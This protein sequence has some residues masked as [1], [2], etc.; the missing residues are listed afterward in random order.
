[1]RLLLSVVALAALQA[2]QPQL[3]VSVDE[4][5]VSVGED[6]PLSRDIAVGHYKPINSTRFLN[7][8][9][10]FIFHFS[11]TGETRLDRTAIGL[12][13]AYQDASNIARWRAAGNGLRCRGNTWFIPYDTIKSRD[14]DRPHPATFPPRLPEQCLRLHGLERVRTVLD[15]FAGLGNTAIACARLGLNFIGIELDEEY[16]KEA[17]GRTREAAGALSAFYAV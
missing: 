5:R 13:V 2:E 12:G 7:D 11:P 8:C 10:E 14:K 1:V 15:P 17:A 4:D 6:V 9:H 16:L 3:D